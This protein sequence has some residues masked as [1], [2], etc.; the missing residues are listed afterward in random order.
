MYVEPVIKREEI[1]IR[2]PNYPVK[3]KGVPD[4]NSKILQ[5]HFC[6]L[7]VGRPESGKSHLLYEFLNN[8]DMYHKKFNRI[9]FVTKN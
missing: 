3:E 5:K 4:F 6:T 7:I 2:T 8:P 9:I 1:E